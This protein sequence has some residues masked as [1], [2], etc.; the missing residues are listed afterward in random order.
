MGAENEEFYERS[1]QAVGLA[2]A[3]NAGLGREPCPAVD[4]MMGAHLRQW[5]GSGEAELEE[6]SK[7]AK[8]L[9]KFPFCYPSGG[10]N[11]TKWRCTLE[12]SA[13]NFRG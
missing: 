6:R 2:C 3:G 8:G 10:E 5:H 13:G 7:L 1:L 11:L 12:I 4:F 9:M